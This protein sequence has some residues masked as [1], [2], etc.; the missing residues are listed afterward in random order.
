MDLKQQKVQKLIEMGELAHYL[1][2]TGSLQDPQLAAV[3][4]QLLDLDKS[5]NAPL[6]KKPLS[7]ESGLCPGCG[8]ACSATFCTSCGLNQDEFFSKPALTCHMCSCLVVEKD[9]FCG[10]CGIKRGA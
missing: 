2:R 3:S 4:G 5:I 9:I 8:V 7:R 1:V 10:V 6:G